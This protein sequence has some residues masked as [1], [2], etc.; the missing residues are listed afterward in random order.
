MTVSPVNLEGS[1]SAGTEPLVQHSV[2][3][4][5]KDV[6][7]GLGFLIAVAALALSLRNNRQLREMARKSG[8]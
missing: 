4:P 8:V 2:E 1:S 3:F 6:L 5:V 7:I